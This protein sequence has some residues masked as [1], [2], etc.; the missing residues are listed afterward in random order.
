MNQKDIKGKTLNQHNGV[1]IKKA[2]LS[3]MASLIV[4]I[5]CMGQTVFAEGE[6][7]G[8]NTQGGNTGTDPGGLASSMLGYAWWIVIAICGIFAGLSI[9]KG[10]QAQAEEDVRGRNNCIAT[11][12]ISGAGIVILL[13]IKNATA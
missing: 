3:V 12:I 13:V 8:G 9:V 6:G 5:N 7:Q 10:V 11:L 4:S 1:K 2:I